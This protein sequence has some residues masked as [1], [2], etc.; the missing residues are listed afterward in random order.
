[1]VFFTIY[2]KNNNIN[3]PYIVLNGKNFYLR[4]QELLFG[5]SSYRRFPTA[6]ENIN[7]LSIKIIDIDI[8]KN[9]INRKMAIFF[10]ENK[11][12]FDFTPIYDSTIE[13]KYESLDLE[14]N[15]DFL[16]NLWDNFSISKIKEI[17]YLVLYRNVS[18]Q[19]ISSY[20]NLAIEDVY[21]ILNF[22]PVYLNYLGELNGINS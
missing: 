4:A 21:F 7:D 12:A 15:F 18:A 8:P 3:Y 19:W 22:L 16:R 13:E 20:F 10:S 11:V 5:R 2:N 6:N 9:E 14:Q 1:M 17:I